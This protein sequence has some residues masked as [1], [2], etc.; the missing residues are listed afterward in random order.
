MKLRATFSALVLAGLCAAGAGYAADAKTQPAPSPQ[1]KAYMDW[2]QKNVPGDAHKLL[3]QSEG[4]WNLSVKTWMTPDAQ[5]TTSA[6]KSSAKMILNGRYLEETSSGDMSGFQFSGQG[7]TA[8]NNAS[9]KYE[10]TW[11]DNGSTAIYHCD[12]TY[13]AAT[14]SI[15]MT[16]MTY[17]PSAGKDVQAKTVTRYVDDKT[18]VFEWWGPD[19]KGKLFKSMEIT[20]TRQ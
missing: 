13:D 10:A 12:G 8:Y 7:L 3:A 15:T 18:R 17:D 14:K 6:G 4:E 16:G 2:M 20:Y 19:A 5:P 1:Q 9:K 11:V